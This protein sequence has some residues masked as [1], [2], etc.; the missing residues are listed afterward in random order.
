MIK[1]V[2][3][4][5]ISILSLARFLECEQPTVSRPTIGWFSRNY[6]TLEGIKWGNWG[7]RPYEYKWASAVVQVKGKKV[8]DLGV[9]LPS[10][11]NWF[12]YVVNVLQP[13]F[14]AGIDWDARIIDEQIMQPH[15]EIR[16]MSMADLAYEDNEFDVAYCISTFEH[17]PYDVF[18]KS[19]QEAHRVLKQDGVLVVTLDERWD[20]SLEYTPHNGWNDLDQSLV[21][22]GIYS[23]SAATSFGLSDFLSLVS[24]YFV[25]YYDE[26]DITTYHKANRDPLLLNSGD[27]YNSCVS[28]VVLKK[29]T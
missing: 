24:D 9:G 2:L 13:S 3:F 20:A 4:V 11:Y 22:R 1:Y 25:P 7:S 29:K 5:F 17:I 21:Q 16:H 12:S 14:Y 28:F 15:Y 19:I 18:M 26:M 23:G 10:Q 27:L 8:I 6:P